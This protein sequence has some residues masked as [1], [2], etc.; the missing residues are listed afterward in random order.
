MENSI[1]LNTFLEAVKNIDLAT[2]DPDTLVDINDVVI[3]TD[4]PREERVAD[5]I[6]QIKNPYIYKCGKAIVKVSFADTSET[7][8]DKLE[9]YLLSLQ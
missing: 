9:S 1:C 7:L 6:K 4:L 8:E 3:N 5:F 2:V